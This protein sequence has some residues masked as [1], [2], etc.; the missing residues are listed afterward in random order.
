MT[1]EFKN[2]A[3]TGSFPERTTWSLVV[4][5]KNYFSAKGRSRMSRALC[6]DWHFE[7]IRQRKKQ[8]T[9]LIKSITA[10]GITGA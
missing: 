4:E 10:A 3:Y 2:S 8:D 1:N 9:T 7:T 5:S 6:L